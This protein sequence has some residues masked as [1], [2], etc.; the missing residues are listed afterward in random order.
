MGM[1]LRTAACCVV[2]AC[3][4]NEFR[5]ASYGGRKSRPLVQAVLHLDAKWEVTNAVHRSRPWF[6]GV[7]R[8]PS[9]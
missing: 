3:Y 6:G 9:P 5:G 2:M 1:A 7:S 4:R 8:S